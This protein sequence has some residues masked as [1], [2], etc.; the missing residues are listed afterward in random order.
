MFGG[1]FGAFRSKNRHCFNENEQTYLELAKILTLRR[2]KLALRRGR[3]FLRQISGDGYNFGFPE[4][5]GG[6]IRSVVPWSRIFDSQEI[7]LAIN[8]DPQQA[9]NAWVVIDAELHNDGQTLKCLYSSN[10]SQI[11]K[12]MTVST[13]NMNRVV[14]LTVPAAGFVVCE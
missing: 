8:T 11:G 2:Q 7:L 3:Q 10:A 12:T 14:D 5:V 6:E 4:M 9:R 1:A 13:R